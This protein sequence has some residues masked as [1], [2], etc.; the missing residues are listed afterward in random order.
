VASKLQ[1]FSPESQTSAHKQESNGPQEKLLCEGNVVK[2]A[3]MKQS[4]CLLML[5]HS[6]VPVDSSI[7][8]YAPLH[9]FNMFLLFVLRIKRCPAFVNTFNHSHVFIQFS[10][11]LNPA[12]FTNSKMTI[13]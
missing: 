12:M 10:L 11:A 3:V 7:F 13:T 2:F 8:L 1:F 9:V 5:V 4:R 6:P